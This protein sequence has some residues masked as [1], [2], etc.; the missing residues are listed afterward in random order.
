MK[1]VAVLSGLK[2][3]API[4]RAD[5]SNFCPPSWPIPDDFPVIVDKDGNVITR[6]RDLVWNLTPWTGV[7]KT[8]NFGPASRSGKGDGISAGNSGI[9]QDVVGWWLWGDNPVRTGNTLVY[10]FD[11]IKP[12]FVGCS[13][14]GVNA[15]DLWKFPLL[16]KEIAIN[17]S[18]AAVQILIQIWLARESLG[19]SIVDDLSLTVFVE[20][21]KQR[22]SKQTPYIPPRIW[23][24]QNLR[25]RQCLND[26]VTHKVAVEKCYQFCLRAYA[27]NCGGMISQKI[28]THELPFLPAN[29]KKKSRSGSKYFGAFQ[30]IAKRFGIADVLD[31]WVNTSDKCG[32]KALASYL[33]L[34]SEVG[35]IYV[36]DSSFMRSYEAEFLRADCYSVE[37]DEL[38]DEV[39]LI[40]GITT[41][42]VKDPNA[43]WIASPSVAVAIEALVS[44]ARL[45]ISGVKHY[46]QARVEKDLIENPYLLSTPYAPWS[47]SKLKKSSARK[48]CVGYEQ[49]MKRWPKLLAKD[50]LKISKEDFESAS[51]MT[52]GLNSKKIAIGKIW[53][54]AD[55]QLRRTG[56]VNMLGSNIVMESSIQYQLKHSSRIMTRYYCHNHFKLKSLLVDEAR[57]FFMEASLQSLVKEF[58]GLSSS[59][60]ISPYGEK[61]KEQILSPLTEKDALALA[62]DA[63]AGKISY[64]KTFF[65]GC[66]KTGEPCPLG[67]V[68]NVSSCMGYGDK[69]PCSDVLLDMQ[70]AQQIKELLSSL[71][72]RAFGVEEGSDLHA[73]ISYNIESTRRALD[74]IAT[75]R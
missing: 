61:R 38:G 28:P 14:A 66:T 35:L 8:L 63:K 13:K 5:S 70:K 2:I 16:V 59:N 41:K 58:Q 46:P 57:A 3:S 74:A 19:F 67:G 7:T 64:R 56:A 25:I 9:F 50:Q 29:R 30:R 4:V 42:T 27:R 60:F 17:I 49:V 32:I 48:Q 75:S 65:G 43:K 62:R 69:K 72:S 45:H 1:S 52:P 47:S 51:K 55:H 22:D 73:A 12:I 34:I 33:N 20:S 68:S 53:P 15:T 44:V 37:L 23:E 31:R 10:R 18:E 36:M 26:Y 54:L 40:G 71:E 21:A 6:F 39:H 11:L 24:Y